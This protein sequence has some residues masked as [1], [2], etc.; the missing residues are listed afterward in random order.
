MIKIKKIFYKCLG[1]QTNTKYKK[2][3]FFYHVP[4]CAGTTFAVLISH[5]IKKNYRLNGP[6][7]RNNDKGGLTAYENYL[8]LENFIHS[9][10]FDFL[11]GH[12]PF[13]IQNKLKN[14]YKF[15]TIVREPI[16]RC[17]SHYIWGLSRGYFSSND[18]IEDLFKQNKLPENVIVNQ[19]SGLGLSNPNNKESIDLSYN[20]LIDNIDLIF[21]VEDIFKLLNLIISSYDFPNLFFQNQQVSNKQIIISNK[22]IDEIKKYNEKDVILYSKLIQNKIIKNYSLKKP[23]KRNNKLYLYSS[24]DLLANGLKTILLN[25]EKIIEI[26]KK[27]VKANYHIRSV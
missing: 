27:L 21:D 5:L 22:N 10:N 4:K 15:I 23:E 9:D 1:F 16:Q 20:N 6:L 18:K 7:F 8:K 11:Y 25:E 13:E 2:P 19:F 3:L 24:P 26:E 12:V 14:N 17:I